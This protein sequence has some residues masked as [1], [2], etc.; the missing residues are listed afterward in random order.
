M[1][2]DELLAPISGLA[3][4]VPFSPERQALVA[5]TLTQA[6]KA[7]AEIL[8][9]TEENRVLSSRLSGLRWHAER[10]RCDCDQWPDDF[11]K[12]GCLK[13]CEREQLLWLAGVLDEK[14]S[15]RW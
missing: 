6:A 14:G 2:I 7:F 4:M 13:L 9:L 11:A 15:V 10:L 8:R 3:D 5:Q 12:S 1:K